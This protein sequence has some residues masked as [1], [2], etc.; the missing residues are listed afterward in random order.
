MT[1]LRV[2]YGNTM[3]HEYRDAPPELS[4]YPHGETARRSGITPPGYVSRAMY[5]YDGDYYV[6]EDGRLVDFKTWRKLAVP[7]GGDA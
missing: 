2:M 4:V 7:M 5:K 1:E 3:S 6:F